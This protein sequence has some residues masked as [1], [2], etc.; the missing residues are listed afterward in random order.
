M[1]KAYI[2]SYK[3]CNFQNIIG[4]KKGRDIATTK[5]R[6]ETYEHFVLGLYV[7]IK[8]LCQEKK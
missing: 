1:M 8:F 2:M 5:F 4:I 7:A 3:N 6:E